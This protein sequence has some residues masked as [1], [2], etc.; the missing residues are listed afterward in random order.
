MNKAL[1][2][3]VAVMV[4]GCAAMEP[5][6]TSFPATSLPANFTVSPKL[7]AKPQTTE[8]YAWWSEFNE[9][10][11]SALV[12]DALAR[13]TAIEAAIARVQ[14]SRALVAVGRSSS[15]PRLDVSADA[16]RSSASL[17][18]PARNP[19]APRASS[20]LSGAAT[21]TW[22]VDLFGQKD[23]E[24]LALALRSQSAE[25]RANALRQTVASDVITRAFEVAAL[26]E[27]IRLAADNLKIENDILVIAKAKASG[28][29]TSQQ[30]VARLQA[31]FAQVELAL[32]QL[33]LSR[34][35]VLSA[36][37]I[38]LATTPDEAALR[39]S[40]L[41]LPDSVSQLVP[42]VATSEMLRNRPDVRAAAAELKAASADLAATAAQRFPRID[43]AATVGLA[44]AS[45]AG[46][47][48]AN[49][50]TASLLPSMRWRVLDFG[51]LDARVAGR[52]AFEGAAVAQYKSTVLRAFAEAQT[53]YVQ[54]NS[55]NERLVAA[56]D[57]Q[58]A[59]QAVCEIQR[60]QY[61]AGLSDLTPTLQACKD[62]NVATDVLVQVR[63][64]TLDGRV[65][66]H[67][68]LGT[69]FKDEA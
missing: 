29:L 13:N 28:G 56:K 17:E 2:L 22:E 16:S 48:S 12:V 31:Q 44:A 8:T 45:V 67:K 3:V 21:V 37:A 30:E 50:V 53:A 26:N 41:R 59:Q 15:A 27:Q 63:R 54:L 51:E 35:D 23:A 19:N 7:V 58:Q 52:K 43:I 18:D 1:S 25:F 36:L 34:A 33:Q 62:L 38:L 4:T 6:S 20:R 55:L 39:T 49:A 24:N 57:A 68:A 66:L 9:P 14:E 69:G 46:L 64:Q 10:I 47:G 61:A 32:S 65:L 11:L 5:V 60:G 42:L 40:G